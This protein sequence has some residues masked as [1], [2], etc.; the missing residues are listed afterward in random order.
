VV[1][2]TCPRCLG[3]KK[4]PEGHDECIVCQGDGGI[5]EPEPDEDDPSVL[6]DPDV[7]DED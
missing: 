4:D 5:D 7:K 6:E 1:W 2:I 3:S